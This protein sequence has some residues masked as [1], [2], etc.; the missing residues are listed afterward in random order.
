MAGLTQWLLTFDRRRANA[1]PAGPPATDH[2]SQ[3]SVISGRVWASPTSQTVRWSN[4]VH[5]F[6][7]PVHVRNVLI[8]STFRAMSDSF[9]RLSRISAQNPTPTHSD[10]GLPWESVLNAHR[11]SPMVSTT[12][13]Y[14]PVGASA[15]GEMVPLHPSLGHPN[16]VPRINSSGHPSRHQPKPPFDDCCIPSQ[17]APPPN[18][19]VAP[20]VSTK[21][22]ASATP[23]LWEGTIH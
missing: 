21:V 5:A 13:Q 4:L 23:P 3:R 17:L 6:L 12:A 9:N 10:V 1:T 20:N 22:K 11:Q 16:L 18:T 2:L 14:T 19:R 8:P 15:P 7:P